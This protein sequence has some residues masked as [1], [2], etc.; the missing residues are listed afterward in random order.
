MSSRPNQSVR[1]ISYLLQRFILQLRFD[2]GGYACL[3]G[4][5]LYS[6]I[7]HPIIMIATGRCG[8][9]DFI[10]CNFDCITSLKKYHTEFLVQFS[11][12]ASN[13]TEEA[14]PA[15]S[16]ITRETEYICFDDSYPMGLP[17]CD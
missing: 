2:L 5:L 14:I 11:I 16:A 13:S 12:S 9:N 4:L 8:D 15:H 1:G 6:T 7:H 17:I 3:C 10:S